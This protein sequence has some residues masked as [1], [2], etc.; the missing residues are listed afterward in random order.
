M[1]AELKMSLWQR[2]K[3]A[4]IMWWAMVMTGELECYDDHE[5]KP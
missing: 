3:L 4:S 2:I 1:K 5:D